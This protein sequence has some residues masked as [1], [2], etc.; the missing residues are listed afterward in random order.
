MSIERVLEQNILNRLRNTNI[1]SE[2]EVAIQV[3]DLFY[4]K[5]VISNEKRIIS[6]NLD[7]N[8]QIN[9][10]RSEKQLLKG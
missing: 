1:I 7:A 8:T 10:T 5:N 4:A 9:E 3:G 6:V 2:Q